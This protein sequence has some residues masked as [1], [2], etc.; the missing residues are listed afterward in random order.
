MCLYFL[1]EYTWSRKIP[2]R[3]IDMNIASEIT[4]KFNPAIEFTEKDMIS[5]L[6]YLGYLT[7]SEEE[8]RYPK[9][10]IS[11]RVMKEIYSDYFMKVIKK[12]IKVN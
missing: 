10:K 8:F 5:M 7:I 2:S 1:T 4:E 11:N 3:L 9:L 6:Y 12:V